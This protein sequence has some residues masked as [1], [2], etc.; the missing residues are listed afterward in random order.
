MSRIEIVRTW[1]E[2][3]EKHCQEAFSRLLPLRDNEV[4]FLNYLFDKGEI[5]SSLL[6]ED[7]ILQEN[8]RL[9]PALRWSAQKIKINT[10]VI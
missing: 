3:L 8:I 2:D 1:A 10:E 7:E 4:E 6:S 5:K 9:H